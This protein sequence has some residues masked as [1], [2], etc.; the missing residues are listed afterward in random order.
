MPKFY[1]QVVEG[2]IKMVSVN[3]NGREFIQGIFTNGQSFG[4]PVLLITKP[5]PATAVVTEDARIIKLPRE[6]F[7]KILLEFPEINFQFSK[8]LANRLYDKAMIAKAITLYTPEHRIASL[9]KTL[10][11]E[12]DTQKKFTHKVELSRQ[13]IADMI[14]FRVETVIRT[15]KNLEKKNLL[16]IEK[17]KI[18]L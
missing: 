2:N 1:Y 7:L 5:Y 15:I 10:K 3:E 11:E 12:K 9:F 18:Y 8:I 14:G 4:E 16:K 17:G 13:A 6:E